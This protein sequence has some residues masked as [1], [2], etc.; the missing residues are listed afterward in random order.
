MFHKSAP[1]LLSTILAA[2]A[3]LSTA[4][5]GAKDR[6]HTTEGRQLMGIHRRK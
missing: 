2:L 1:L 3:C 5:C 4:S 6:A